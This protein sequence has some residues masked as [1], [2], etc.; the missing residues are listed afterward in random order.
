MVPDSNQHP[1]EV[2]TSKPEL[3]HDLPFRRFSARN[4]SLLVYQMKNCARFQL[5]GKY[6]SNGA[7]PNRLLS[8]LMSL[9]F[10]FLF[11]GE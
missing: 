1:Y 11:L 8:K 9:E 7:L 5:G 3:R 6:T 10:S 2:G 4:T